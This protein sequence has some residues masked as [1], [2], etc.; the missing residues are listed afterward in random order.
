[1][2]EEKKMGGQGGRSS[3][4]KQTHKLVKKKGIIKILVGNKD[5]FSRDWKRH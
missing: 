1:M 4:V 2:T 3:G 5:I